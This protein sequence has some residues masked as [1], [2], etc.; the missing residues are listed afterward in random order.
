MT[1]INEI[2]SPIGAPEAMPIQKRR[3]RPPKALREAPREDEPLRENGRA[4]IRGRDGEI[5]TRKRSV[6]SDQFHIPPHIVPDGWAYQW[7][8]VTVLGEPQIQAQIGMRE[9]G[10]RPVPLDRHKDRFGYPGLKGN[11]IIR[12]GLRLEERP[13]E[14]NEEASYEERMKANRQ[15]Q[16]QID[17]HGLSA[18]MPDGFSRDNPNLRRMERSGT[19]RTYAP[20]PDAP[21]PRY[22]IE[23]G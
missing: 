13:I 9:N 16:D 22:E 17:Q 15:V 18:R 3:G 10:W 6:S 12:D 1:D 11:E 5:L 14:L 4:P 19:S 8:T 2:Q 20:A 21:R 23:E 7:N